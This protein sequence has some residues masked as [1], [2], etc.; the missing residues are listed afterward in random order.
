MLSMHRAV[1]ALPGKPD[2]VL[3]D[4]NRLPWGHPEA[5]RANGTIRAADP[6]QPPS[7][8]HAE[9]IVKGDSKVLAIAAASIIAKVIR[10]QMMLDLDAQFPDYGL[11]QHKGYPV[12][13]HV[14]AI[15]QLGVRDFH[16]LTFAPLKGTTAAKS[17]LKEREKACV[18]NFIITQ[19]ARCSTD[20][21]GTP[22]PRD[23]PVEPSKPKKPRKR[24]R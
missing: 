17:L 2:C 14:T 13:A 15:R 4:G 22:P 1:C 23:V 7:V 24:L 10:D 11:A 19:S 3:V 18:P 21:F 9:A 5:E 8:R 12:P 20:S 16:R 6:P